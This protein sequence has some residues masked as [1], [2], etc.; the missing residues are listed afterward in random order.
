MARVIR[1]FE[2]T[3]NPGVQ[4]EEFERFVTE[5]LTKAPLA[6]GI[7]RMRFLKCDRDSQGDLVG[8]YANELEFESVEVRDRYFPKDFKGSP[9]FDDWWAEHGTLW[10][11]YH[12]MVDGRY[13]DYIVY[14][15]WEGLA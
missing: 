12:A 3:L 9:E 7:M 1:I 14:G 5:D 4:A 10:A 13:L 2:Y 6:S 15:E 8:T 11:K